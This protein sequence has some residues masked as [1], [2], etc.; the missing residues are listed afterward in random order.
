MN[1]KK[2][3]GGYTLEELKKLAFDEL[4]RPPTRLA[5]SYVYVRV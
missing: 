3:F 1:E 5:S 4:R 2:K